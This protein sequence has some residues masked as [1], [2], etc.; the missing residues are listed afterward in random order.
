MVGKIRGIWPFNAFLG[1]GMVVALAAPSGIFTASPATAAAPSED[2]GVAA[3]YRARG[4]SPLWLSPASGDAAQQLISLLATAQADHLN[5]RHYN[6]KAL[7]R[8]L[9]QARRDPAAVERVDR[10]LSLAFVA[11]ASDQR[12]D[13]G[14]IIYVE[15]SIEA[16]AALGAGTSG[17]C[18]TRAIAP[19]LC[20]EH[21][22]DEPDLR[23]AAGRDREPNV[24]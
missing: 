13:P 6:A 14:G 9:D 5:P 19:R 3:F 4:G 12:H 17:F 16:D 18:W 22:L 24:S 20:P 23:Q 2:A 7:G 10:M 15:F 1:I 11:Y 21:G 8:A